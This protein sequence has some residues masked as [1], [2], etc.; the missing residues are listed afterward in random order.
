MSVMAAIR[1]AITE[2]PASRAEDLAGFFIGNQ[3]RTQ[4]FKKHNSK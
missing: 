1:E 3:N 4:T 2:V